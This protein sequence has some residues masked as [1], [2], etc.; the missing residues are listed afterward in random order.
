[1]GPH[2]AAVEKWTQDHEPAAA[3][4][5][6]GAIDA[7]LVTYPGAGSVPQ[8]LS[9]ER[10]TQSASDCF[11]RAVMPWRQSSSQLYG[12]S[13]TDCRGMLE[14]GS[15]RAGS[16]QQALP[17]PRVPRPGIRVFE[18]VPFQGDGPLPRQR[19][20]RAAGGR[21][22]TGDSLGRPRTLVPGVGDVPP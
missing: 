8:S 16:P 17:R 20:L 21:Q 10:K 13:P 3:E 7:L 2:P 14:T 18:I 6:L 22:A 15:S 5:P 9:S 12:L 11:E 1:V 4:D 19:A